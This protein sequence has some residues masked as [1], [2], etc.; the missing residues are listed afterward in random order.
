[1]L[2]DETLNP[3]AIVRGQ[4]KQACDALKLDAS[5]YEI[6]K[7]PVRIL[8]VAIPVTMDDGTV[9]TFTGYRSQHNDAL[10]PTK[11][12]IRFH[13]DVNLDEVRALSMW[14][15]IKCS[16]LGLPFGGGKGGVICN[17]KELSEAELEQISRGF[18]RGVSAIVGPEKDV[19]APDVYTN[20]QIMA[21]MMDEYSRM[22]R[23]NA[24]ALITGKPVELGGSLGRGE[25]TGRGCV[26][27]IQA[28]M[29]KL[30]MKP[31]GARAA[32]QGFGN[33]GTVAARLLHELGCKV[34]A[35]S[36]SRG[37]IQAAGGLDIPAVIAHKNRTGS[38]A[39]FPGSQPIS[40]ADLLTMDCDVLVP[41]A[42]ENQITAE[43]A[44][45]IRAKIVAEAANGPTT[46]A[47]QEILFKKGVFDL[48]DVLANAGGVTVSY[49]EWVQ[50]LYNFYWTEAEVNQRMQEMM[51]RAFEAVYAL[52]EQ[53][54]TTMRQAA[55]IYAV[56]RVADAMRLRGWLRR[57]AAAKPG[58]A[59]AD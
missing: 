28:A 12:G 6:L 41:A 49:F 59:A 34:I 25:A 48:P 56:K 54:K 17:P 1:M 4:V 44:D 21:W 42:L 53:H 57:P 13:P 30:G 27:T 51:E 50:N 19:P 10:G 24:F 11:G 29:K 31:A 5:A 37:G 18:I 36:D 23:S 8:E 45:R 2:S 35:V 33:A 39:G 43:N 3:Y 32:V 55:Y 47:A 26:V 7:Q 52:K 38:V 14:M 16:L 46:P 20:P 15:T 58:R 9:R 22:Q 40:N